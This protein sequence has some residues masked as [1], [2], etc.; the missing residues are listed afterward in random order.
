M[1]NGSDL[2][3]DSVLPILQWMV[4]GPEYFMTEKEI[5]KV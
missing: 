1:Y 4:S 2:T 3:N 5:V